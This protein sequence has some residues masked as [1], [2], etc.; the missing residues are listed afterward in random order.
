MPS[1]PKVRPDAPR[2]GARK[3][4][5]AIIYT[6]ARILRLG[7][8]GTGGV[9]WRRPRGGLGEAKVHGRVPPTKYFVLRIEVLKI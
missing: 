8:D 7:G 3:A 2:E 4:R 5:I 6:F 9:G 1:W